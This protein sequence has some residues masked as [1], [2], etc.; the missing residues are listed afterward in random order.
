MRDVKQRAQSVTHRV[1]Q[2]RLRIAKTDTRD[3][4]GIVHVLTRFAIGAISVS[5]RQIFANQFDRVNAQ[6]IREIIVPSAAVAF[7]RLR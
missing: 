3:R 4:R 6:A 1:R 2:C 7:D 5:A